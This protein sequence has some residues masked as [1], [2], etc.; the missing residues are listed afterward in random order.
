VQMEYAHQVHFL[1]LSDVERAAVTTE[2]GGTTWCWG[3]AGATHA[4]NGCE[5][6]AAT[7]AWAYWP[8]RE[9]CMRPVGAG[10]ESASMPPAA[11]RALL[12]RLLA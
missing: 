10:D 2:L 3:L 9:N 4:D 5:R 7:L 11:F 8:S 12:A 6:F 1:L